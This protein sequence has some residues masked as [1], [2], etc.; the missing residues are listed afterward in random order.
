MIDSRPRLQASGDMSSHAAGLLSSHKLLQGL[1][2]AGAAVVAAAECTCRPHA[3]VAPRCLTA[4]A[5]RSCACTRSRARPW[6]LRRSSTAWSS[7]PPPRCFTGCAPALT[8]H[9]ACTPRV[10]TPCAWHCYAQHADGCPGL[11]MLPN[12]KRNKILCPCMCQVALTAVLLCAEVTPVALPMSK[13]D[14]S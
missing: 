7:S 11:L 8:Q 12:V 1:P 9:F 3:L 10:A 5:A 13:P 14:S 6:T 2:S 4:P